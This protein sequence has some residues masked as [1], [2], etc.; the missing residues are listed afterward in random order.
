MK[1]L[2]HWPVCKMFLHLVVLICTLLTLAACGLAAAPTI[3]PTPSPLDLVKKYEVAVNNHDLNGLMS[4]LS[5]STAF[6]IVEWDDNFNTRKDVENGYGF[7][8]GV[9]LKIHLSDCK[10]DND[11]ITCQVTYTED[12]L[13]SA[14][15]KEATFKGIFKVE[16]GKIKQITWRDSMANSP[17][18]QTYGAFEKKFFTWYGTTYPDEW[19]KMTTSAAAFWQT[20]NGPIYDKRCLE[21]AATQK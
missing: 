7:Y 6:N 15:V 5:D 10:A 21:Y 13:R 18:L 20:E 2:I 8:F 14:G 4:L 3:T 16:S 12:C 11:V 19:K 1:T 17:T 9:H